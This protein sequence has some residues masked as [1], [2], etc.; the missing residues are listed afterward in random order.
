MVYDEHTAQ[1][2]ISVCAP[3]DPLLLMKNAEFW[4]KV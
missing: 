2:Y 3:C 1:V 4:D